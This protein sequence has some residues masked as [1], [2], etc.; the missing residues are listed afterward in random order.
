L[1][2]KSKIN[3]RNKWLYPL[4]I[5]FSVFVLYGNSI[6]NNYSLDDDYV[7]VT[8]PG[9]HD[10]PRVE[11]GISGIPEIFTTHHVETN[12]QSFAYRPL[13]LSTFA[14]EYHFFK[15]S[16][17]I[18]H[19]INVLLY[20]L[21]CLLV[22]L[23]LQNIFSGLNPIIILLTTFIFLVHPL[24][25][26][27]VDSLKNRDELLCFMFGI[28][29]IYFA[30]RYVDSKK[31]ISI[32]LSIMSLW[33]AFLSK[34]TA[35]LF[36]PLILLTVYFFKP[37]KLT[38]KNIISI[39]VLLAAVGVYYIIKKIMIH[40]IPVKREYVFTENPLFYMHGIINRIPTAISALGYYLKLLIVPYPLSAYYGYNVIPVYTWTS[41]YFWISSIAYIAMGIFALINLKR[42]SI[43]SYGIFFFLI[44]IL[45]Y[46]NFIKPVVGIVADRFAFTSSFGF[47][48]VLA[49]LLMKLFKITYSNIN[50]QIN[51]IP[52]IATSVLIIAVFAGLTVNR[53]KDW[54]DILT[55]CRHDVKQFDD[56]YN[57]H[58]IIVNTLAPQIKL[59]K[60][61][62]KKKQM[63]TEAMKHYRKIAE[64]VSKDIDKYPDDY[65]SR[66]NLG[67]I[68][69]NFL[70][71]LPKAQTLFK[72][73]LLI[74][75]D[76][77]DACY[78]LAFSYEKSNERDSATK[79]YLQTLKIDS[80]YLLAY[81][82]LHNNYIADSNYEK[83]LKNGEA[84]LR[85][86]PEQT[87]F[88]V[89]MGN[90]S[91]LLGDTLSGILYFKKA[92]HSEP[93]NTDLK[94][95]IVSFLK[96]NGFSEDA[97]KL[98]KQ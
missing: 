22:F 80:T 1:K 97:E 23:L 81:S 49:V 52:F 13:A 56:S 12:K 24:H 10:N 33:L 89:N 70:N 59:E 98:E 73:A 79:Y 26:E 15:S 51:R 48:I 30:V 87:E 91:L 66:N 35:L 27:V 94:D 93:A 76:N 28:A 5:I 32:V 4:L 88:L 6:Q 7:T 78:N 53:N 92:I 40:D 8:Q 9:K 64:L 34:E 85:I 16:P 65:L 41:F 19:L 38:S 47:S 20:A 90:T 14:I 83:A 43:L 18:S 58:Y 25:T 82:R 71:D 42:K 95:Q 62:I 21:I 63:I 57:L 84:A 96:K 50:S 11:K 69:V 36:L 17:H 74:K 77:T 2:N 29:S 45:P 31:I 55:L 67:A 61:E 68:Y 86:F 60:D 39:C 37:F 44:A 75:P 3:K 54:K 46:S 72:Q